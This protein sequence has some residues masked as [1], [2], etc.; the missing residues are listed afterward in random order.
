MC[1]IQL[2]FFTLF[3]IF[4]MQSSR[5]SLGVYEPTVWFAGNRSDQSANSVPDGTDIL[6]DGEGRGL[7]I[8]STGK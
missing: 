7:E 1:K 5:C 6:G 8:V 4:A 3:K 2:V